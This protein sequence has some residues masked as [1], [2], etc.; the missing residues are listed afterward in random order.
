MAPPP[1]QDIEAQPA[2]DKTRILL[3][4]WKHSSE[5]DPL[6]KHAVVG[7]LGSNMQLRP[8]LLKE[9]RFGNPCLGNHP[10][11]AG[12]V[13]RNWDEIEFE[14]HIGHLTRLQLKEYVRTRLLQKEAG[15]TPQ[16]QEANQIKA[17]KQ[18]EEAIE[19]GDQPSVADFVQPPTSQ[20]RALEVPATPDTAAA[21][22]DAASDVKAGATTG[23]PA[24]KRPRGRLAGLVKEVNRPKRIPTVEEINARAQHHI[25][26]ADA[27]QQRRNNQRASSIAAA[28]A[29]SGASPLPSSRSSSL[30]PPISSRGVLDQAMEGMQRNWAA[31]AELAAI[32][33]V[34]DAKVYLGTRYE[35]QKDGF[36]AGLYAT[37]ST[38]IKIGD[39]EFVENRVLRRIGR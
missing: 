15:E 31:Q 14:P 35:H 22:T 20:K 19:A 3:G 6:K 27:I 1:K 26:K 7:V 9:D 21:G 11:G 17:V 28:A 30:A 13:W 37:T 38:I 5:P 24:Q 32:D 23:S 12:G 18:A 39:E 2:G 10:P 36:F 8:R 25:A 33:G 4:Y 16:A 34:E 29:A